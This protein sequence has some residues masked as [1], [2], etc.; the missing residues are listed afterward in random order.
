MTGTRITTADYSA[1]AEL[2]YLIRRFLA[3][4][5]EMAKAKGITP[6]QH[7]LMLAIEGRLPGEKPTIRYLA[8]RLR[9]KH[10]S[11]VGL[12]D[13]LCAQGLA[14]REHSSNDRREVFVRLTRQGAE[15][16]E[17]LSASHR[18]ELRTL[19]PHLVDALR[20]VVSAT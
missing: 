3:S 12:V 20:S 17:N 5:E 9:V 16:L 15:V 2:R 13:R 6:Q 10:H 11:A 4:S 1:L 14:Q 18:Q 8:E 7:Q 19:A